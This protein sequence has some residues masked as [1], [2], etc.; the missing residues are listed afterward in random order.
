MGV[1]LSWIGVYA[2]AASELYTKLGLAETGQNGDYYDFPI[3]GVM[4]S[5]NWF[6]LTAKGCDHSIVSRRVL[7]AVS[8]GSSAI[9]CSIEEHV[10]YQSATMWRDGQEVWRVQHRGGDYGIMDLVVSGSLPESFQDLRASFYAAQA[11]AGGAHASVDHIACIPLELA[12]SIVGFKHDEVNPGIELNSFREL[13]EEPIGLL[14]EDIRS[15][16]KFWWQRVL[17]G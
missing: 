16:S 1:S 11:A 10:M 8:A 7:S 5:T 15:R 3:A 12:R 17:R 14:F 4:L 2:M 9:G 13:R 6:L